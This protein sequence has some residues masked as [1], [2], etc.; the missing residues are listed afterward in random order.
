MT[1][2]GTEAYYFTDGNF[3]P[4]SVNF[5]YKDKDGNWKDVENGEGFGEM[6]IRDSPLPESLCIQ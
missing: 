2:T 6:C 4:A 1:I 5:Q 3:A